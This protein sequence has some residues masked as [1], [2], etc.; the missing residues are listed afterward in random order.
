[1][2][3]NKS[4]RF[5]LTALVVV[6]VTI[7][8]GWVS[9]A[10]PSPREWF[11]ISPL[12]PPQSQIRQGSQL[13]P[14]GTPVPLPR[15][16]TTSIPIATTMPTIPPPPGYP[17]GEPWP[18]Q[19]TPKP[20]QPTP[21]RPPSLA[22]SGFPPADQQAL[23]YVA[24]NAGFPELHVIGMDTQGRKQLEFRAVEDAAL[25]G[26]NL[27]GLNLVGLYPS[28]D[29]KYLALE[30]LGDGYGEVKIVERSS[31]RV[32]CP[33]LDAPRG[34]WGGFVGWTPDN[35]FLFQPFDV[36][37]EG[38]I[39]LGV[40]VVDIATG[41]YHALDLPVSPDG[42]YSLA[43]NVLVSPD[44]TAV[45]YTI[46]GSK[47]GEWASEI[48]TMRVDSTEKQLIHRVSGLIS[49]LLWSPVG[50]R[51]VYVRSEPS[52][53]ESGELWLVNADGSAARLLA[54]DLAR[55]GQLHFR[56]AWSPDG[57]YVAFIQWEQPITF[58][59]TYVILAWSNVCVVDTI[60]GQ[61]IRLSSFERR[62]A[63]YPTWS[64]DSR[65]VAF[66]STGRLE[67]ESLY[68]E[69][70]VASVDGSQLYAVSGIAKPWNAL[71]WLPPVSATEAR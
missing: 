71:A 50:G 64:P 8:T 37:P 42:A 3:H 18:P 53:P 19:V 2:K 48:W 56:P 54:V 41:Q 28:P 23:Y 44:G 55:A 62:E 14:L 36:P 68:S 15:Q 6:I 38:V 34:C 17:T 16:T 4:I 51:V 26:I 49:A 45:A 9:G 12:A 65:F 60:T 39:S 31:G 40:I 35:H 33:L 47:G 57:R 20:Q 30:F 10:L 52:Q 69:V 58:D 21:I 67:G 1:M 61:I 7:A 13:S 66:V 22:P 46:T 5:L 24:N 11:S 63:N 29:G 70:W 59:G 25:G 27:V 32:W 43:R